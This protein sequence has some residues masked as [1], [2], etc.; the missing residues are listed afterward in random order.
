MSISNADNSFRKAR[1]ARPGRAIKG[2]IG[3]EDR[4]DF[5]RFTLSEPGEFSL[6]LGRLRASSNVNVRLLN[7][8]GRA[9]ARFRSAKGGRP[10]TI[11]RSLE[12]GTYYIGIN[13]IGKRGGNVRYALRTAATPVITP[14]IANPPI[15]N[16][17]VANPP[18]GNPPNPIAT[19]DPGSL[20]ATARVVDLSSG[21]YAAQ[22]VVG[23]TD[24]LDYYR[25]NLNQIS[26]LT[27]N[28]G[29]LSQAVDMTLFYD[30]NGN[31][32]VDSGERVASN[33]GSTTANGFI[34]RT[35]P[36]G[37]YFL[38][39][40]Y[41]GLFNQTTAYNLALGQT[42]VPGNLPTDP[43]NNP[44]T[45]YNLGTIVGGATA[46]DVVGTIDD[47][48]YF[49]FDL[50]QLSTL[51]ANLGGL[52]EAVDLTLYYDVNG[53]GVIDS[54]ERVDVDRGST[55]KNAFIAKSLPVGSYF[56]EID[57]VGNF[58][59]TT[60]YELALTQTATPGNLPT[61]PSNNA[62]TAYNLGTLTG[63]STLIDVVGTIDDI[64]YYKFNL[65]QARTFTANLS[66]LSNPVDLTLFADVNGNGVIDTGER[67]VVDRG[68]TTENA[69]ISRSLAAGT[70]FLE[71]DYAGSF[72]TTTRYELALGVA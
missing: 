37:T 28:L 44:S 56:L 54:G 72:N 17:P 22:E 9:L 69:F 41:A 10:V 52:S 49:K 11:T 31:G 70:Y 45:A 62:S 43:S 15:A 20:P 4:V 38:E 29:G 48:D 60:R 6:A 5:H 2:I 34:A 51:S 23:T 64:D 67:V 19:D 55:A 14:P 61:D 65:N 40:D 33:R 36:V 71:V 26:T 30:A 25:F 57:Y 39:I 32:V 8:Q 47:L 3:Q 53:N 13:V 7:G 63:A 66:G 27:A 35:L 18:L 16:P 42:P 12:A 21:T 59:Q 1:K 68:S 24:D 58:S 46:I 50:N